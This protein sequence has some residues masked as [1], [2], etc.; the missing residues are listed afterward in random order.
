MTITN[1]ILDEK[2]P[3][4]R[5]NSGDREFLHAAY[6]LLKDSSKKGTDNVYTCLYSSF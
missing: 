1:D 2:T 3:C 6:I 5:Y 4:H